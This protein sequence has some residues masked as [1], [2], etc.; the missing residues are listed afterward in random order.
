GG[1]SSTV[2]AQN[3]S[4]P[5][6]TQTIPSDIHPETLNR[7]PSSPKEETMTDEEKQAYDRLVAAEPRFAKPQSGGTAVRLHAPVV[8]E[9]FRNGNNWL[10]ERSGL[11]ARYFE[12]AVLTATRESNEEYEWLGHEK[13]SMKVLPREVVEVVRNRKDTRGLEEK[14]ALLIQFSREL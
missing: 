13:S 10:R 2:L 14:D 4:P 6:A 12:L 3:T 9:H 5:Q 11:D 8:A 7:M 1:A